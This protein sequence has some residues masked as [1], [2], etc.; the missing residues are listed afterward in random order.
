VGRLLRHARN[1]AELAAPEGFCASPERMASLIFSALS[2]ILKCGSTR[3]SRK[4][5]ILLGDPDRV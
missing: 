2:K 4:I 3:S 1:D 5:S